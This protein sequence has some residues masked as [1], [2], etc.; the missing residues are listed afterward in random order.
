MFLNVC[1]IH[2]KGITVSFQVKKH[3]YELQS[4]LCTLLQSFPL[5]GIITRLP[6]F[7]QIKNEE[8]GW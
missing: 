5:A 3:L 4:Y 8:K 1:M 7:I 6:C 2:K